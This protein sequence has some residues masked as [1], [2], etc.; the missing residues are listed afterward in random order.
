MRPNDVST[1]YFASFIPSVTYPL[2]ATHTPADKLD[3]VAAPAQAAFLAGMG[4]N[5][6]YPTALKFESPG[7]LG[8]GLRRLSTEKGAGQTTAIIRHLRS[9]STLGRIFRIAIDHYQINAGL[10]RHVLQDTQKLTHIEGLWIDSLRAFLA[11]ANATIELQNAWTLPALRENDKHLMDDALKLLQD[12]TKGDVISTFNRCR[13]Y[14]KVTTLAELC[15]HTGTQMLPEAITKHKDHSPSLQQ[16]GTSTLTWPT[17]PDPG[18][19]SWKIWRKVL[20]KLYLCSE[21]TKLREEAKLGAWKEKWNEFPR[22]WN[23]R[24]TAT[25]ENM[26]YRRQD[27]V[28]AMAS[29]SEHNK[30]R[31]YRVYTCNPA[32]AE[33][34]KF[35]KKLKATMLPL[36]PM[37]PLQ[38][39]DPPTTLLCTVEEPM[40]TMQE[41]QTPPRQLFDF[42]PAAPWTEYVQTLPEWERSLLIGT[43]GS[44]AG[45]QKLKEVLSDPQSSIC[46][47]SSSYL[48]P[49]DSRGTYAWK[50]YTKDTV[51][52]QSTGFAPGTSE[53]A[54]KLRAETTAILASLCY[55][56]RFAKFT[57][58]K[59]KAT[60]CV[61]YT[62][63][64]SIVKRINWMREDTTL[65]ATATLQEDFDLRYQI[66][67][68]AEKLP[69]QYTL[70]KVARLKADEHTT[71]PTEIPGKM[72]TL[73]SLQAKHLCETKPHP[74]TDIE[75][76]TA[77]KALLK[78]GSKVVPNNM[79]KHLRQASNAEAL[80]TY[81]RTDRFKWSPSTYRDI[82]WKP[83]ETAISKQTES[84]RRRISKFAHEWLPVKTRLHKYDP[85]HTKH[86]PTCKVTAETQRH[87]LGCKHPSR[88]P[89][90]DLLE[91]ELG[92]LHTKH[93]T[94]D[95]LQVLLMDG[96]RKLW[97]EDTHT[98]APYRNAIIKKI[99]KKQSALG[100]VQLFYGRFSKT[101]A[102][103]YETLYKKQHKTPSPSGQQWVAQ[104]IR[105]LWKYVKDIWIHR[106]DDEH[107]RTDDQ[108]ENA[109]HQ[110]LSAQVQA[111][112]RQ[113]TKIPIPMQL[114]LTAI[115]IATRLKQ[116]SR[117][118]ATWMAIAGPTI[119]KE[120][121]G[122]KTR[123][124]FKT[125]DIRDYYNPRHAPPRRDVSTEKPP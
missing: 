111:M 18:K 14:L 45:H 7:R 28:M 26:F 39:T 51:I 109:K 10:S 98:D 82:D 4:Y 12:G 50:I 115:P 37:Q 99:Y 78:I 57:E 24:A 33:A 22:T 110:R 41:S 3:K 100:W 53:Y 124:K 38:H 9:E 91:I 49:S 27:G 5:R 107:G 73:T 17:Q 64:S 102:Q 123:N 89:Y 72:L 70:E 46:I 42:E 77:N 66:K 32:D 86:C 81:L 101:W 83:I 114:H 76:V 93:K 13:I 92:I 68:I 29:L 30:K 106:N 21:G 108:R 113:A 120:I 90:W 75:M 58:E 116:T 60:K 36:L 54:T 97:R 47:V 19:E 103:A 11:H 40:P 48:S 23:Y 85:T 63:S 84:D 55:L 118:L 62:G 6:H 94:D 15:D 79:V 95:N 69:M 1:H 34:D 2:P 65:H 88:K 59:P 87:F 56:D 61:H 96:I 71:V 122:G 112:Y 119:Q 31:Q 74:G 20:R 80:E 121:S 105:I 8:A 16:Y 35:H 117:E 25:G 44:I 52:V 43:T 125:R 104:V 67:T